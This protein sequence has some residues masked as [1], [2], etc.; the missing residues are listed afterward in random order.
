MSHSNED[1]LRKAYELFARGQFDAFFALCDAGIS[2]RCPGR[3]ALSGNHPSWQ[4]FLAVVGPMMQVTGGS[5]R[6]DVLRIIAN[7]TDGCVEIAQ[8]V[9]RDGKQYRWGAV[10]LYSIKNGKLAAFREYVDDQIAFD[11]AWRAP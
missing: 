3:N 8:R 4:A 10:H 2:F 11:E 7:D 1:L 6:E 5:F 9:E